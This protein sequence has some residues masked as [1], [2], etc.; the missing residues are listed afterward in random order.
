MLDLDEKGDDVGA[1]NDGNDP[2]LNQK[3]QP[4]L[5][6][7]FFNKLKGG[8]TPDPLSD[9]AYLESIKEVNGF[10]DYWAYPGFRIGKFFIAMVYWHII[11]VV[12]PWG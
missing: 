8:E 12:G 1:G 5:K 11:M 9:K 10:P 7:R 4:K 2:N 6:T 3:D